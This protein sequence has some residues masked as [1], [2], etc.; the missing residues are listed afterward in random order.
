[1]RWLIPTNVTSVH[2]DL[3]SEM[4]SVW[5]RSREQEP[6]DRERQSR[7]SPTRTRRQRHDDQGERRQRPD[8]STYDALGSARYRCKQGGGHEARCRADSTHHNTTRRQPKPLQLS[9]TDISYSS[10]LAGGSATESAVIPSMQALRDCICWRRRNKQGQRQS[11]LTPFGF[12]SRIHKRPA[13]MS[14][15]T[16]SSPGSARLIPIHRPS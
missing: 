8:Y 1:M 2:F 3:S 9:V 10:T 16:S 6:C 12:P 14:L 7:E 13:S 5:R 11:S 15:V 4:M